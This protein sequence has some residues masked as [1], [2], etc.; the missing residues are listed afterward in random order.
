[1]VSSKRNA[2]VYSPKVLKDSSTR[3][4][5][6]ASS[7]YDLELYT[8]GFGCFCVYVV[9]YTSSKEEAL[10]SSYFLPISGPLFPSPF[11]TLTAQ[12][13]DDSHL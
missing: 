8:L 13:I 10:L 3:G 11:F 5:L 4:V 12:N 7:R 2:F 9:Y 1:M 6:P